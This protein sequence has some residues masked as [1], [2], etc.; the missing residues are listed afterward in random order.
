MVANASTPDACA[1]RVGAIL[2]EAHDEDA[3][4]NALDTSAQDRLFETT[5]SAPHLTAVSLLIHPPSHTQ[6]TLQTGPDALLQQARHLSASDKAKLSALL[7]YAR[8]IQQTPPEGRPIHAGLERALV[9]HEP[10]KHPFGAADVHVALI[11]ALLADLCAC[12]LWWLYNAQDQAVEPWMERTLWEA[13]ERSTKDHLALLLAALG[14]APPV[15]L[16][17]VPLDPDALVQRA[18]ENAQ[19]LARWAQEARE[20]GGPVYYPLGEPVWDD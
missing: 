9:E 8:A 1:L 6:E 15:E 5:R 19:R 2:G 12:A 16:G 13:L 14:M 11:G 18:D 10:H 4:L 20:H 3:L 17:I 7:L